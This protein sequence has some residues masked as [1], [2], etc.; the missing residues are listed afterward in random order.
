[1]AYQIE[2]SSRAA[3]DFLKLSPELQ[4]RVTPKIDALASDPRPSGCEKLTG[5][6]AYRIRA[7]DHRV[8]YL[9]DDPERIITVTRIGHRRDVYRGL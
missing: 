9:V 7:G 2:L 4:R 6:D 1:M 5:S 8:V 3:R